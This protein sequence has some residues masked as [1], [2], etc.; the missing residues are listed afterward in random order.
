M[1]AFPSPLPP[2][3]PLTLSQYIERLKTEEAE[4]AKIRKQGEV[5]QE[6]LDMIPDCRRRLRA[7]HERV[8]ATLE[9]HADDEALAG[10]DVFIEAHRI[11]A[12]LVMPAL[13]ED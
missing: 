2:S 4:P 11:I 3:P 1:R 8:E 10:S 7:A 13:N 12:E 9:E 5:L 6:S